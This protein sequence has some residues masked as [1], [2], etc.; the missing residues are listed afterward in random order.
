MGRTELLLEN[1]NKII[2]ALEYDG[3]RSPGKMKLHASSLYYLY[4]LRKMYEKELNKP[5]TTTN[6]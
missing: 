3:E 1:T 5:K 2:G 6:K 4:N